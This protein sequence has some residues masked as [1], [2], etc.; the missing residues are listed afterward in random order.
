[1]GWAKK[2]IAKSKTLCT[3]G[4]FEQ[5]KLMRPVLWSTGLLSP[6][7]IWNRGTMTPGLLFMLQPQKVLHGVFINGE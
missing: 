6:P 5:Q 2:S 3:F 7:W 4:S 1:M